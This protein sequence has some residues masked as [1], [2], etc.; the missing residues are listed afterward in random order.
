ML[1]DPTSPKGFL[2]RLKVGSSHL[3]SKYYYYIH[4]IGS[5]YYFC[6]KKF[7]KTNLTPQY[8]KNYFAYSINISNLQQNEIEQI[9]KEIDLLQDRLNK[10]KKSQ[11]QFKNR[12]MH[13]GTIRVKK[14]QRTDLSQTKKIQNIVKNILQNKIEQIKKNTSLLQNILA[15]VKKR[16]R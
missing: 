1:R 3:K 15:Q 8:K 11:N 13:I 6:N 4:N 9:K 2:W 12:L 7:I 14:G 10:N 16:K 5:K